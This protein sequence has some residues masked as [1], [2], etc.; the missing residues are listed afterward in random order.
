MPYCMLHALSP[1]NHHQWNRVAVF[2]VMHM[3]VALSD[4]L[5]CMPL[6]DM[7]V[8]NTY[9]SFADMSHA[10]VYMSVFWFGV[11]GTSPMNIDLYFS[12]PALTVPSW[13]DQMAVP[14][15]LS[16]TAAW[17]PVSLLWRAPWCDRPWCQCDSLDCTYQSPRLGIC[18]RYCLVQLSLLQSAC[19]PSC[20]SC[21]ADIR[22]RV[23]T[24]TRCKICSLCC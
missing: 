11:I 14:C 13:R 10:C 15:L 4:G 6:N 5:I 3:Y 20:P 8:Y 12:N 2:S 1:L 19:I 24:R 21:A 22:S 17:L 16:W 23:H 18:M 9:N 7:Y